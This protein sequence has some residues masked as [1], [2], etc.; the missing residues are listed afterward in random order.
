MNIAKTLVG[1]RLSNFDI[2]IEMGGDPALWAKFNQTLKTALD[3][4]LTE[5][6][7]AE[8][9]GLLHGVLSQAQGIKQARMEYLKTAGKNLGNEPG[10][11]DEQMNPKYFDSGIKE[12]P[13]E[14]SL[15]E[16]YMELKKKPPA[17]AKGK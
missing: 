15:M 1:G 11:V 13:K 2:Q 6:N 4:T 17:P 7:A 5:E 8:F 12:P 10:K 3:G 16:Q 14:K 9:S